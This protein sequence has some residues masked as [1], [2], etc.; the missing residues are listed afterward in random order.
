MTF[1]RLAEYLEKLENITSRNEIT[2]VLSNLISESSADDS[3][4]VCYLVL[5]TLA[6]L[7][8]GI[9]LNIAE[10]QISKAISYSYSAPL[11]KV[12]RLYSKLGDFGEVVSQLSSSRTDIKNHQLSYI[13]NNLLLIASTSGKGSQ[14]SKLKRLSLL[15]KE[16]DTVSAKYLVRICLKKLRLGFSD[17]SLLEAISRSVVG[18][19]S[20]KK[21]L[22]EVYSIYPDIGELCKQIKQKGVSVLQSI[23]CKVGIPVIPQLCQRVASSEEAFRKMTSVSVEVKY[24]G[25]RV[26]LHF[27][28]SQKVTDNKLQDLLPSLEVSDNYLFKTFTRNLEENTNMFPDLRKAVE[29]QISADS[30]IL[31]GEAV[32]IDTKT[33]KLLPF[34]ETVKRKRK[35]GVSEKSS[36]IPLCFF[37]F[38]LLFLNNQSL[39]DKPLLERRKLLREIFK[40]P[41]HFSNFVSRIELTEVKDEDSPNKVV[42]DL[43]KAHE[44]GFE[45]V[46]LKDEESLYKA[47]S[48]GFSWVKIKRADNSPDAETGGLS[49]TLDTVILGYYKGSGKRSSFGIGAF[50]VGVYDGTSDRF[51]TVAKIGTGLSD[52]QWKELRSRCDLIKIKEIP[53][54]VVIEKG[55][56]PDVIVEPKL[57]VVIRADEITKSPIHSSGYGLRFPRLL[58]WRDDKR[59][60][61][62]TTL[63]EYLSI[64]KMQKR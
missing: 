5:G 35:H 17:K 51:L 1:S 50:L 53:A 4:S 29:L 16:S 24:D 26:Q 40:K 42:T 20:L 22:E 8:K 33:G 21:K 57:V 37:V 3:Q 64:Y 39:L 36:E 31:D 46:V 30:A 59:A 13:Y 41:V 52:A 61:Q 7:F 11:S 23:K 6:P 62:S 27:D 48:R 19:K 49:D 44:N 54:N 25:T 45:G 34:Q 56:M 60:E 47:G 28:R 43:A 14:D 12:S 63:T 55:I 38:D 9:E 15:L 18:D 2:S 32:G 58:S 10:K